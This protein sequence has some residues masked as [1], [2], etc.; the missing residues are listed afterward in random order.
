MQPP[1]LSVAPPLSKNDRKFLKTT[2]LRLS[3]DFFNA[4]ANIHLLMNPHT[5]ARPA[6]QVYQNPTPVVVARVPVWGVNPNSG[7]RELG[8]LTIERGIPPQQGKLAFPG[9]YLEIE[10]WRMGLLRELKEETGLTIANAA[11]VRL[12]DAHSVDSDR[13][14]ALIGTIPPIEEEQLK[15]SFT[16]SEEAPRYQI[17]FEAVELAFATHTLEARKFFHAHSVAMRA[18]E[19]DLVLPP[20]NSS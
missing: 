3:F 11:T 15:R 7:N 1:V 6:Q 16:P 12:I 8:L 9:G 18:F 19:T 5:A 4:G 14:V 2:P 20:I 13:I 10:N 17:I